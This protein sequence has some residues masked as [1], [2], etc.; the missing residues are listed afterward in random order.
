[1]HTTYIKVCFIHSVKFLEKM[2]YITCMNT[3]TKED[4]MGKKVEQKV[5]SEILR[6]KVSQIKI[7][8]QIQ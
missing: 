2:L 6:V 1:M 4:W 8:I 3:C 7:N 5:S